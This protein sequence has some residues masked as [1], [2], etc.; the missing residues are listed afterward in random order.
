MHNDNMPNKFYAITID[1]STT[2]RQP[3]HADYEKV[4][5]SLQKCFGFKN[6]YNKV[7]A[8]EIKRKSQRYPNWI[9]YHALWFTDNIFIKY[10]DCKVKGYSIKVKYLSKSLD[11]ARWAGYVVKNKTDQI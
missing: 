6:I 2:E 9:H 11:V 7:E 1:K 4:I 10:T 3:T 5:Q 8:Y